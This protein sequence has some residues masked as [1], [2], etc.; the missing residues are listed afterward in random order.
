[1]QD[2]LSACESLQANVKEYICTHTKTPPKAA[3]SLRSTSAT[4][5]KNTHF[6]DVFLSKCQT[7]THL[8]N[9]LSTIKEGSLWLNVICKL[10][11]V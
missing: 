9:K 10:L 4:V 6:T 11:G 2:N 3:E 1:M 8:L 5:C 7:Y